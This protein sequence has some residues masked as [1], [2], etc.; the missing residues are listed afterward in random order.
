M[1]RTETI[2]S[3]WIGGL[4]A[5]ALLAVIVALATGNFPII[6]IAPYCVI[7]TI[8]VSSVF[9]HM[10]QPGYPIRKWSC[11]VLAAV[12]AAAVTAGFAG[13]ESLLQSLMGIFLLGFFVYTIVFGALGAIAKSKG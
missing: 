8:P 12:G 13:N 6:L 4:L 9:N 10:G 3:N 1:N 11:L 7:M 5:A 2:A